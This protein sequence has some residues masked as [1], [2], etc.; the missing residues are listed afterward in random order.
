MKKHS[1]LTILVG[2]TLAAFL[3]TACAKKDSSSSSSTATTTTAYVRSNMPKTITVATPTTLKKSSSSRTASREAAA[4]EANREAVGFYKMLAAEAEMNLMFLDAAM[5]NSSGKTPTI[6][7]ADNSSTGC[8]V[9]GVVSFTLT[10]E[11]IK[12]METDIFTKMGMSASEIATEVAEMKGQEGT[13]QS[14]P[15]IH[16]YDTTGVFAYVLEVG[17]CDDAG[18]CAACASS[19]GSLDNVSEIVKWTSD[20]NKVYYS[21]RFTDGAYT[22]Q[23]VMGF[24]NDSQRGTF[25]GIEKS[26]SVEYRIGGEMKV[27][28]TG[29]N[30]IDYE[31]TFIDAEGANKCSDEIH[32]RANDSGGVTTMKLSCD[33]ET[34]WDQ[35]YFNSS[36]TLVGFYASDNGTANCWDDDPVGGSSNICT[37]ET[38]TA[39]TDT[40]L[41]AYQT[42]KDNV[43]TR[44]YTYTYSSGFPDNVSDNGTYAL[45]PADLTVTE[46]DHVFEDLDGMLIVLGGSSTALAVKA[47][48]WLVEPGSSGDNYSIYKNNGYS[49]VMKSDNYS[50]TASASVIVTF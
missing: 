7:K 40:S 44:T 21:Q 37:W 11:M 26:S 46:S 18:N 42:G 8:Q 14:G 49:T 13:I 31:L 15:A 33:N 36:G 27:C 30:C 10:A 12:A 2:C 16:Y 25:T 38:E 29:T 24:D 50:T 17:A 32:G 45:V 19:G 3:I 4:V 22:I 23:G 41:S 28:D 6:V 35:E 1:K 5:D 39:L 48:G 34:F 43:S 9:P 20:K 47:E